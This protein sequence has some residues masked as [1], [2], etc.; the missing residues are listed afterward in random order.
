MAAFTGRNAGQVVFTGSSHRSLAESICRRSGIRL[1]DC[2]V[3][4]FANGEIQID[5]KESVRG[6]NVFI[7]QTGSGPSMNIAVME[8]LILSYACKTSSAARIVAV[9]PYLPYSRQS[10]MRKRGSIACK[11]VAQ[12]MKRSGVGHLITM[13]LHQKEIQG[14]FDFPVDNL[15]AS[16]FLIQYIR[17][18][19]PDYRNAVLVARHPGAARRATSYSE[20]LGLAIAVV[21]GDYRFQEK[22]KE[23]D[24]RDSPPPSQTPSPTNDSVQKSKAER[25]ESSSFTYSIGRPLT[26]SGGV[27]TESGGMATVNVV[28]DVGGRISII[29]DDEIDDIDDI[30]SVAKTLKERGSYKIYAMATHGIFDESTLE[31]LESSP[32]DE[33][34]VTN[35][36]PAEELASKCDKIKIVDVS[37]MLGEAIRRIHN[38]E[39]M[40]YLFRDVP[41]GD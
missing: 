12:M 6:K 28:G 36:L 16:P 26:P 31:S 10:R 17:D 23:E 29:V 15:R 2:D 24:G 5:I 38:D 37:V 11:L 34:V 20:R 8:L 18:N 4:N 9:M 40:S 21:H 30:I 41:L 33:V 1:G 7:I 35:T 22:E 14:F 25:K 39:S 32:I 19:I 3:T 13:D 27:D